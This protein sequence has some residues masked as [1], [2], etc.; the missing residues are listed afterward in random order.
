MLNCDWYIA[1]LET[2]KL[3]EKKMSSGLFKN[4]INKYKS[5]IFNV[6]V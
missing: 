2:I 6:Y 3:F 1:L 5:Y 4:V